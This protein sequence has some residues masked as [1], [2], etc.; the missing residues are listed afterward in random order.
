MVDAI[1]IVPSNWGVRNLK[2]KHPTSRTGIRLWQPSRSKWYIA[3][4]I[5]HIHLEC[6]TRGGNTVVTTT[7]TIV[8][9]ESVYRLAEE[10][11]GAFFEG[12]AKT[13]KA[14]NA[15]D[16]IDIVRPY[17]KAMILE[18][19]TKLHGKKVLEIGSGFGANLAVWIKHYQIDGFG[20]ERN[21]EGFASSYQASRELFVANG[22]D[23]RRIVNV[24]DDTLPFPDGSF[25]VVYASNVLEHTRNPSRV[26]EEAIRVL[27]PGGLFHAE[28]PNYLSYFEGHYMLPQ[29]P[30]LWKWMLPAWVRLLGRDPAFARTMRTEINPIWCRRTVREVNRKYP[31]SLLSVGAE[32]FLD[33]LGRPFDFDM[34]RTAK[35]LGTLVSGFQRLNL[36]NWIGRLIVLAQG[37]YPIYLT[38]RRE[39]LNHQP[40]SRVPKH[41]AISARPALPE[42]AHTPEAITSVPH[43][44]IREVKD[45][46]VK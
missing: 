15:R 40:R 13:S 44:V 18:R 28:V 35:K 9:P 32:I 4:L 41:Q 21:A 27:R 43:D 7:E 8:I 2:F 29:P 45:P 1:D 12:V 24:S 30:L 5:R 39:P 17:K 3:S 14:A 22:I 23:P 34:E 46:S 37:H 19:Y 20:T 6:Y 16:H 10:S 36:G 33:R 38:V 26:I 25:D 11:V 42:E 31:I